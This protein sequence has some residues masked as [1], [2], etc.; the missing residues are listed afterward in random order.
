MAGIAL[1]GAHRRIASVGCA[2]DAHALGIG[3]PFRGEMADR[4]DQVVGRR[5][6]Q[7]GHRIQESGGHLLQAA[8]QALASQHEVKVYGA[9]GVELER[10]TG[11]ANRTQQGEVDLGLLAPPEK[12]VVVVSV[13]ATG[14]DTKVKNT[15]PPPK[16]RAFVKEW[17]SAD[18]AALR[19]VVSMA[20]M[21]VI[22]SFT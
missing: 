3:D 21:G 2:G 8:D 20:Y 1:S 4:V 9:Q 11:L 15:F 17:K 19:V 7:I 6:R 13:R 12:G 10:Y 14:P 18:F 16:Q 5:Y 22:P